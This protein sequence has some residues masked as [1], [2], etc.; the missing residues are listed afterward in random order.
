M[1][2]RC[3][4]QNSTTLPDEWENMILRIEAETGAEGHPLPHARTGGS[5]V[6]NHMPM[7]L[8]MERAIVRWQP[9]AALVWLQNAAIR[10]YDYAY[11][12]MRR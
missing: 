1:R 7:R 2:S 8:R 5:G 3:E 9:A 12:S 10:L 11:V 4:A 6:L